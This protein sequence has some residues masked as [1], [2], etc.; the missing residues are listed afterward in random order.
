MSHQSLVLSL[1]PRFAELV[2]DGS[3]RTE[4]RRRFAEGLEGCDVFVYVTSPV[5]ELRGGFRV[6][7]I[8]KGP[9]EELWDKVS[10]TA[11][12]SRAQFDAYYRGREVAYAVEITDVWEF[13]SPSSLVALR[14]R[15]GDFV[16]PQSWRYVRAEESRWLEGLP[17]VQLP[18]GCPC[19]GKA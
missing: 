2:F 13:K 15:L 19:A 14:E 8:W 5:R 10:E 9:P 3:K 11:G 6:E 12:V 16:V 1:Q 18:A 4:L 17:K 7:A